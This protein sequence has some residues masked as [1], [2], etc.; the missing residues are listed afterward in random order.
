MKVK[1]I[2][3]K[4]VIYV[5]KNDDLYH[6]LSLME[7]HNITKLPVVDDGKIVGIVTDNQIADK[8]GSIRSKGVPAARMHASSVMEKEF[9][10]ITPDTEIVDILKSVGE[11]GPTMLPV[12]IDGML[13]GVVTKA[14]LLPLIK[15]EKS[16]KEIMTTNV[17]TARPED[18]VIHARR[19]MLDNDIA[20]LPVVENG[21]VVGIISDKEIAFAFASI[22]KSVSLGQQH[23]RIRNLLVRDVMKTPAITARDNISIKDAAQIMMKHEVGCLPIV[24]GDNKIKGI[25]TRTDLLRH[26]LKE[27]EEGQTS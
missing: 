8:L 16:I 24:G 13:V 22:K 9:E 14:D 3:T 12:A 23:N 15:S 19:L 26:L 2:M 4:D 11:P 7:K 27:L 10:T 5:S 17:I 6:V 25:V 18:R 21:R 1:E 20:R